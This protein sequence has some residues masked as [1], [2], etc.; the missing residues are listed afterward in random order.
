MSGAF[1][2]LCEK[3]TSVFSNETLKELLRTHIYK[4]WLLQFNICTQ[5]PVIRDEDILNVP[6]PKISKEIQEKISK[7]IQLSQNL[8][9]QSE[10]LLETVKRAVEIAIEQ[11]EAAALWFIEEQIQ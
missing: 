2:V 4:D 6:I 8:K 7:E 5:Y 11:D 3:K 9:K 1:T 10:Q